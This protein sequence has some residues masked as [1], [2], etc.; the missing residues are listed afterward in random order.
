M[1]CFRIFGN[2][3][4]IIVFPSSLGRGREGA[5]LAPQRLRHCWRDVGVY[6]GDGLKATGASE[7]LCHCFPLFFPSLS[8]SF[9]FVSAAAAFQQQ[10]C[11]VNR[12]TPF[13][14]FLPFSGKRRE[15]QKRK[16]DDNSAILWQK[17]HD[18][19][20]CGGCR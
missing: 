14:S 9:F 12:S 18:R 11:A 16:N 10:T 8:L 5:F 1:H 20:M 15:R 2:F 17:G 4:Y 6:G 13:F 19:K 7:V 3:Q